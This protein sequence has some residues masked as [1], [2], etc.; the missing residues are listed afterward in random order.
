[1]KILSKLEENYIIKTLKKRLNKK[2][3]EHSINVMEMAIILAEKNNVDIE[4][5]KFAGLLHDCAKNM[6]N[7]DLIKYCDDHK[8]EIDELKRNSPGTL[9]AEVGADIAKNEFGA[10]E[11]IVRAIKYHTLANKDM[12]TLD[13]ILYVADLIELGRELEGVEEIR[14]IA[15][16]DLNE[17]YYISLD[18]CIKNVIL[19]SLFFS[20]I[21][22]ELLFFL[23]I[24]FCSIKK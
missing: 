24:S 17:G 22:N 15:L 5:A 2:R 20:R 16:N 9:H 7:E 18:Y 12:K 11:E 4:N 10:N 23:F 6:S 1:M 8:I 19:L 13:K 3:L 14:E 21:K